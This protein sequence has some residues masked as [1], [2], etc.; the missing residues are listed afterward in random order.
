MLPFNFLRRTKESCCN[1]ACC[2]S[3]PPSLPNNDII[4]YTFESDEESPWEDEN[5]TI[6]DEISDAE[7][8]DDCEEIDKD[9]GFFNGEL[10]L[11]FLLSCLLRLTLLTTDLDEVY[12][13]GENFHLEEVQTDNLKDIGENF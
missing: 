13:D 10:L 3:S 5:K 8:S 7:D 1:S 4:K 6:N 2:F 9:D 11:S 12:T